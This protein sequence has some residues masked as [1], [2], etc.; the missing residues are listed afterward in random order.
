MQRRQM[1]GVLVGLAAL[2]SLASLP[3]CGPAVP[4]GAPP[5]SL[6]GAWVLVMTETAEPWEAGIAVA[7][8]GTV[9]VQDGG[10]THATA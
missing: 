3:G 1:C 5:S 9:Q 7:A 10:E 8:D 6:V 4:V 2:A